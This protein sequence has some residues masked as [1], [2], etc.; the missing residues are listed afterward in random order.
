M[1]TMPPGLPHQNE[2]LTY[3]MKGTLNYR[4]NKRIRIVHAVCRNTRQDV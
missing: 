3:L 4:D 1:L 2:F